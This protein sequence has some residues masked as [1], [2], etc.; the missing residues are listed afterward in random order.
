M[1]RV[2]ARGSALAPIAVLMLVSARASSAQSRL[3]GRWL[4]TYEREV[5]I[6][7]SG[8][9]HIVEE[10]AQMTLSQRGDSLFGVWQGLA[11]GTESAPPPRSV[12]GNVQRD[13]ASVRLEPVPDDP[14]FFTGLG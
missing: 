9:S 13:L 10:R 2:F 7:H 11:A 8:E 14:G 1:R 6:G 12:R 4:V 5:R 3:G